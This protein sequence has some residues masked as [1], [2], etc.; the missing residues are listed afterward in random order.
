V[1]LPADPLPGG[2]REGLRATFYTTGMEHSPIHGRYDWRLDQTERA[3][4][5][6]LSAPPSLLFAR[7][8]ELGKAGP[9]PRRATPL[10]SAPL[11][12]R[13]SHG[14]SERVQ[15]SLGLSH[16]DVRPVAQLVARLHQVSHPLARCLR[17]TSD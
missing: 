8:Y 7:R 3:R 13:L 2:T 15:R 1:V 6:E 14:R 12:G 4:W 11:P 10:L 17:A 9:S 16:Q 5:V